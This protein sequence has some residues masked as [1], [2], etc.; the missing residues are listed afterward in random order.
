MFFKRCFE[1][2]GALFS[3]VTMG[4]TCMSVV[5][6][7]LGWELLKF[8]KKL[9]KSVKMN[10][11]VYCKIS[12][13]LF[14]VAYICFQLFSIKI[15]LVSPW[16]LISLDFCFR[17]LWCMSWQLGIENGEFSLKFIILVELS[18][19]PVFELS[20][21]FWFLTDCLISISSAFL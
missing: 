19:W 2:A 6:L 15:W 11:D 12:P 8:I 13:I 21:R 1:L 20:M 14:D 7:I 9:L 17:V 18:K 10:G 5:W 4:G 16:V 3:R